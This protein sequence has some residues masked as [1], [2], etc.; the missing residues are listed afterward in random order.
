MP[1]PFNPVTVIKYQLPDPAE[2][3]LAIYDVSGR[4]VRKLVD[5]QRMIAGAHGATWDG[6]DNSGNPVG[7]GV[8]FYVLRAGGLTDARRMVLL[9]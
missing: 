8:Y 7:S 2:V 3:T 5:S 1:N 6:R 4:Q 9:K